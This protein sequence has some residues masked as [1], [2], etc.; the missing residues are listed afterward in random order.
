[1][2]IVKGM[3]RMRVQRSPRRITMEEALRLTKVTRRQRV[4]CVMW[5]GDL[6]FWWKVIPKGLYNHNIIS[7]LAVNHIFTDRIINIEY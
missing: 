7:N 4:Y 5:K 2:R 1:M 3:P 6:H